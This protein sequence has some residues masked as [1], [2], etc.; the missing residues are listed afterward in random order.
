MRRA[1]AIECARL[2]S[3]RISTSGAIAPASRGM[4]PSSDAGDV[5]RRR[6]R[7]AASAVATPAC[8]GER[9]SAPGAR[10]STR[11]RRRGAGARVDWRRR[12]ARGVGAR[13]LAARPGSR[14]R[15]RRERQRLAVERHQRLRGHPHRRLVASRASSATCP[16]GGDQRAQVRRAASGAP[17]RCSEPGSTP[18]A[19]RPWTAHAVDWAF[20]SSPGLGRKAA[21]AVLLGAEERTARRGPRRRAGRR[22]APRARRRC[23]RRRC[24]P[25]A[26]GEAEAAVGVLLAAAATS[27]WPGAAATPA[28]RSASTANAVRLT[29]SETEPSRRTWRSQRARRGRG[30][31]SCVA[32]QPGRARDEDR[33][34]ERARR[35]AAAAGRADV[36]ESA[37]GPPRRTSWRVVARRRRARARP[38]RRTAPTMPPRARR[39]SR[40]RR[41]GR[42]SR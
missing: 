9:G 38:S 1:E 15:H 30:R 27:A 2:A 24:A 13:R 41:S 33:A 26:V 10:L 12:C 34:L 28:A 37:L 8:R 7:P 21:V 22:R 14:P 18:A 23:R 5:R 42:R 29:W 35:R 39:R 11:R 31:R 36:V 20:D 32:G 19:S 40:R 6:P 16:S 17:R 3:R 25:P 4:S